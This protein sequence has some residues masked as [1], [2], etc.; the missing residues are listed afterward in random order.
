MTLV[1]GDTLYIP[2]NP[3]FGIHS[4]HHYVVASSTAKNSS[5][6]LLLCIT[7]YDNYK[8]DFC[9]FGS[10]DCGEANFVTHKSCIDYRRPIIVPL[11]NIENLL[12]RRAAKRKPA[13]PHALL[14]RI[15]QGATESIR[16]HP[17]VTRI[18]DQQGLLP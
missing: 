11:A 4:D 15:Y 13:I 8:D 9:V 10:A 2:R 7:T 18:L 3:T 5:E 14:A 16:V 1:A 6:V 12:S 17:D